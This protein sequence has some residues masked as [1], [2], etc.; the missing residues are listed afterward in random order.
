MLTV[1]YVAFGVVLGVFIA[2][3]WLAFKKISTA[4]V[5]ALILSVFSWSLY[6]QGKLVAIFFAFLG[7]FASVIAF[8]PFVFYYNKIRTADGKVSDALLAKK[9]I[10]A[11]TFVP[12]PLT[13]TLIGLSWLFVWFAPE[14]LQASIS[15]T[16]ATIFLDEF[17]PILLL[18]DGVSFWFI[19]HRVRNWI[20]RR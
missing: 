18:F 14:G 15:P 3:N 6:E 2:W 16:A 17:L 10:D 20:S 13:F 5:V 9:V 11:F 12:I 1:A 19:F 7:I 8:V 4:V